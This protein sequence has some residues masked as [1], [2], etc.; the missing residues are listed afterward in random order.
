MIQEYDGKSIRDTTTC[1]CARTLL[2]ETH[3]ELKTGTFAKEPFR[4][5]FLQCG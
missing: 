4:V 3:G 5:T 2:K 1:C